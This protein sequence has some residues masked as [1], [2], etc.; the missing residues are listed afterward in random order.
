[1]TTHRTSFA[2]DGVGGASWE[3]YQD[4]GRPVPID[5]MQQHIQAL[6]A[7]DG[8]RPAKLF[9]AEI[10]TKL[11]RAQAGTLQVPGDG[12]PELMLVR[13]VMEIKWGIDDAQWRLY[14]CEPLHLQARRVMLGLHFD[15][16]DDLDQQN[17]QIREA[18]RR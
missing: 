12:R 15:R 14:Y 18:A 4:A 6:A 2:F 16:K 3:W 17:V 9:R 5:E 10:H 1:L 8:P 7:S 13:G 11:L